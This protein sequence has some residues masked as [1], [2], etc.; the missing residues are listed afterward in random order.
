MI[1]A[2]D[3]RQA[4]NRIRGEVRIT[5][6]LSSDRLNR[7]LPFD[8]HIKADCL[9]RTGSFKFRGACNAV[10]SLASPGQPVIAFSS[11]NHAQAVALAAAL[12]G[13]EATIIMPEDAPQAKIDGTRSY[14]AEVVLYN[15]YSENREEIGEKLAK[16][17]G[18]ELIR[19]YDD[20]R[21][22]A[23]QGT[24]GLEIAEQARHAGF[25]PD[26]FI[27]C[28]GG[29]G[30]MAGSATALA[31]AFSGI[32]LYTAEP[33]DFNDTERSLASGNYEEND[34]KARSICDAIVTPTPGRITF[35]IN[36]K[37]ARAGLS[38]T[39]DEALQAMRIGWDY[40]KLTIEPGGAVALAT[41][42]SEAFT[43]HFNDTQT[44][45]DADQRR[46]IVVMASGGNCDKE[47]FLRA[48]DSQPKY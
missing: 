40:F 21:V 45:R 16:D 2:D 27:C 11:G 26:S 35:P 30:L 33:A 32:H 44:G 14:G 19:P 7:Q 48:L 17:K 31:D 37:L 1:T 41:A 23:G 5:P 43:T 10:F 34:P 4:E 6:L 42:L 24:A 13:R 46:Q 25:I 36:Q 39:D 8:L 12:S 22:I 20:V 47:M 15:R 18:A 29:G 9:Q 38:V 28:C 3:I